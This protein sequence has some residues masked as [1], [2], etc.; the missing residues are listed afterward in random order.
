MKSLMRVS[1]SMVVVVTSTLGVKGGEFR[2]GPQ[3]IAVPEGF[4][5]EQAAAPPLV[6]RPITM[7]FD[8]RGRLYVSDSS[9]SNAKVTEQLAEKPHRI[10]RLVD[11]DGDGVFDARTVFADKMMLP[12]GTLWNDGSLYV[13][14][15]PVIWKLTDTNDDG[16]ADRREVWFDGKTLTGCANDLHGPYLGRDGWIYWC[17]GAFDEQTHDLPGRPGWKTRAS[18]IFRA[19]SDGSGLEPVLTGGMDN[20]VDVVFTREGERLLT[21]TFLQHPGGGKRDGLIHAIYG[22]VYGKEHGVLEGH[23]RTGGLMPPMTHLGA[24]APC[25]MHFLESDRWGADYG[26]SVFVTQFNLRKVS[27]HVLRY[28]GA[29]LVTDD[30][31]FMTSDSTDFHPTDVIEDADGSLLVCD[32]GGWYKLCCPTSQIAKPEV[33]GAIYRVR[34]ADAP[35]MDDPRGLAITLH[36]A[37]PSELAAYLSDPRPVMRRRAMDG[38][39]AT[40]KGAVP[41]LDFILRWEESTALRL[42]ALWTLC[43]MPEA[44]AREA[45]RI[46]LSDED[47]TV[48]H[49]ACQVAGLWRDKD[50]LSDLARIVS[51]DLAP[52]RRAAAEA[53]GRLGG[54]EAATALFAAMRTDDDRVLFHSLAFAALES[55]SGEVARS[56]L[57]RGNASAK[58]AALY[59]LEQLP[60]DQLVA[61]DLTSHLGSENARL[62]EAALWV[63]ARH[64]AWAE[65]LAPALMDLIDAGKIAD[66]RPFATI[67]SQSAATRHRVAEGSRHHGKDALAIIAATAANDIPGEWLD[68]LLA[69]LGQENPSGMAVEALGNLR[70]DHPRRAEIDEALVGRALSGAGN[71]LCALEAVSRLPEPLPDV[72]FG[73]LTGFLGN[74]SAALQR[75]SAS[76]IL[77]RSKLNDDQRDTL[78]G[79]TGRLGA[80]ELNSLLPLFV[81]A[82]SETRV[83]LFDALAASPLLPSLRP[84]LIAS[85]PDENSGVA[86][87]LAA[88]D[89]GRAARADRLEELVERMVDADGERGHHVF[90][91]A[92]AGCSACHALGYVGGDLGPDL[93]R[94]GSVR[95]ERDLLEAIVY[96]SASFVRSYEPVLVT[97]TDGTA[98]VGILREQTVR[99]VILALAPGATLHVPAADLRSVE[100]APVSLMPPG[101]D[102]LLSPRELTDLARFLKERQ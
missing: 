69:A 86:R 91:S 13:S 83:R 4:I 55:G 81:E 61:D 33:S 75:A 102:Q 1:L 7:D 44:A 23:P 99:G 92:K 52:I 77:A 34:R 47:E 28:E 48:R 24:A 9:G 85:I 84:D 59:V 51:E 38:L 2:F 29:A 5:V 42:R 79:M 11:T 64:P 30:L 88:V 14:A 95:T 26:A 101:L 94:I 60:G 80:M 82:S 54:A 46:G 66:P 72:I 89:K 70:A 58:A 93:S 27:R 65:T 53:L 31:D 57:E 36:S 41:G 67:L 73:A 32:T 62:R 45:A 87:L 10:L 97:R 50:A 40:G 98:L 90:H 74:E 25:G 63:S 37:E 21:C 16:V 20:P 78:V 3:T 39:V 22:G 100:A 15:P 76:R 96:P 6:G 68:A 71:G 17:K 56:T 35:Q 19:R 18:H 43:R 49:A 12:E 8:E